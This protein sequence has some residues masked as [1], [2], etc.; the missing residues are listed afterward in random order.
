MAVPI[1]SF[2]KRVTFG[3]AS[4]RVAGVQFVTFRNVSKVVLCGRRIIFATFSQYKLQF[5]W[6][7]RNTLD[8]SMVILRG[9]RRTLH[10]SG[11]VF[12]ITCFFADRIVRAASSGDNVQIQRHAW[13]FERCD[14]N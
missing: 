3:V 5:S 11:Y 8:V 9:R 2:A 12:R 7:R 1:V 13:L 6:Q 4:F 10:V 14:E